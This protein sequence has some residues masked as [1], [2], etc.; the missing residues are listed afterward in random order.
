MSE[1]S[2]FSR[3]DIRLR[4]AIARR[5]GWSS[6]RPVQ[7]LAGQSLLSGHNAVILAPTAGGKT[8]ASI[9]PALSMLCDTSA[10]TVGVLYIAPIKALLNNQADRLDIYTQMVGLSRFVW[11]GDVNQSARKRFLEDPAEVLMTTPESLEVMLMS[12]RI[13][14]GALFRDLRMVIIDEVHALAGSDRGAHLLSVLERIAQ[15]SEHDV[16]RVGLSATVGNPEEILAWLQGSSKR[17]GEVVD[18]L[19]APSKKALLVVMRDELEELAEDAARVGKGQKSLLFCQ[20]RS[21][22]EA[23]ASALQEYGVDVFVHHSSVSAEE[24]ERAEA[25]FTRDDLAA[26]IA[27]TSTLELGIDIG[28]LDKVLQVE[29]TST[30]SAF[31][32]RLGRTGRRENTIANT[33]FL[34]STPDTVIQACAILRLARSGWVEDVEVN[35]RCWPVLAHQLMAM[36]LA[37]GGLDPDKAFDVLHEVTDF[38]GITRDE[39]D[40]LIEHMTASGFLWSTNGLL[41]MGDEGERVFG[42]RNFMEMYAVFSSPQLFTVQ[43]LAGR[44]LGSLEQAFVDDLMEGESTF[45]LAG[46]RWQVER[47]NLKER[48]VR[49]SA[50]AS[51]KRPSW[52]SFM[53]QHLG[54]TLCQQVREVLLDDDEP[55]YLHKTA[56][57]ALRARRHELAPVLR[58]E[59]CL[60]IDEDQ[61]TWWTFAGGR[62]N[63]TLRGVLEV[64]G[65]SVT[66]DNFK[67][68]CERPHEETS[69]ELLWANAEATLRNPETWDADASHWATI[70]DG[71]PNFR[72]SKFQRA[73]PDWAVREMMVDF[74]LAPDATRTWAAQQWGT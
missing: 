11:H 3:F 40:A 24:R 55:S 12:S 36:S 17:P 41:V 42:R 39:Y 43:T 8:E 70:T 73:L 63:R 51:G 68:I 7:E 60:L 65:W 46:R 21:L 23:A 20:S 58:D 32:Q 72:L 10:E 18:P 37:T 30:V 54:L 52:T 34:C 61:V 22:T 26:C 16:Q 57:E 45:V 66:H 28:D 35:S 2:V 4:E 5:L 62:I 38:A 14:V 29:T 1:C 59:D 15:H 71:L 6:L 19:H 31:L 13:S 67:V 44:E 64:H 33:T 50:A 25:T 53:P 48:R 27:C 69:L 74:L 49:V 56:A 47:I 9:F